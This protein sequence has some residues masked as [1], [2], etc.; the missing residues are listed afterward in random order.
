MDETRDVDVA[1]IG[2][3]TV[4]L[5]TA[6]ALLKEGLRVAL[7]DPRPAASL[8]ASAFDGRDVALSN[9]ILDWLD[10]LTVTRKLSHD[11]RS[12]IR[13]AMVRDTVVDRVLEFGPAHGATGIGAFVP[14]HRLRDEA[15]GVIAQ[16]PLLTARLGR[17]VAALSTQTQC[18]RVTLDDGEVIN[19][20]L[21][22]AADGRRSPTRAM[23]GIKHRVQDQAFDMVCARV[24]HTRA[25][26]GWTVQQFDAQGS[27][28]CLPLTPHLTSLAMMMSPDKA[29]QAMGLNDS[30]LLE[31]IA[32]RLKGA[33]GE[34]TI[35]SKRYRVPL[36]GLYAE[37]FSSERAVLLGDAAVGMLPITA[38]GLNLGLLGA[39]SL[40]AEV[41]HAREQGRDIGDKAVTSRAARRAHMTAWPLYKGTQEI[42]G[43]F[44]RQDPVSRQLR[45]LM[46]SAAGPFKGLVGLACEQRSARQVPWLGALERL[47]PLS[48]P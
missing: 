24:H 7:I 13:G 8:V 3:G 28:A 36:S 9:G 23:L 32:P 38:H 26:D 15:Y 2:A 25:H 22:V 19:T 17:K 37:R 33:L 41:V 12:C 20:A 10:T 5:C 4:G 29:D 35:A 43:L 47:W 16:H 30:A 31:K 1:V 46:M 39:R 27:I 45:R 6:T 48:R 40:V 34:M 18:T 21:V 11:E 44:M 42:A 14:E